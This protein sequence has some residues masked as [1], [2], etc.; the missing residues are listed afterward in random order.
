MVT[1][2]F[3]NSA[4][5]AVK[6]E[7]LAAYAFNIDWYNR[8]ARLQRALHYVFGLG[9][10]L[11]QVATLSSFAFEQALPAHTSTVLTTVTSAL[12][13]VFGFLS[14]TGKWRDFRAAQFDLM[15]QRLLFMVDMGAAA[16]SDAQRTVITKYLEVGM[17]VINSTA[18]SYWR[19]VTKS[20]EQFKTGESGHGT[21]PPGGKS[22]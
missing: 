19:Q 9:I 22:G 7:M 17:R 13:A 21:A 8:G 4:V 20:L 10:I 12:I 5:C 11:G 2:A 14:P 6:D 18:S 3:P 1:A 15:A 16:D